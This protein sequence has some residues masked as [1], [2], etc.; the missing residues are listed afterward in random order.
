MKAGDSLYALARQFATTVDKIKQA[1]QLTTDII[2]IGQILVI[3]TA[4]TPAPTTGT[5]S[6]ATV[7]QKQLQSLGY[8]AVPTMTG[9]Y[10]STTIQALKNFQSD[11][12]LTVTGTEDSATVTAIQHA[13]VKKEI[14]RDTNNYIGVPY[15]WGGA[16]PT[17]FDCSGFVYFMFNKHGVEMSRTTSSN[18]YL[19][20]TPISRSK[21]Q[22]GDLVY[23]AVNSPGVISHVGFYVGDNKFVSATSSKGIQVVSLDN[24]YWSQYYVGAKRIY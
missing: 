12:G 10:D 24:S 6:S 16:T 13:L 5:E 11:Y 21:L 2:N 4:V 22:P 15:L 1:N 14:V 7:I 19:Q 20:G 17:G 18:L 23:Y 3:P 9:T 8:Y